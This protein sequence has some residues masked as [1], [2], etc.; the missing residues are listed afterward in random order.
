VELKCVGIWH[1]INQSRQ[2]YFCVTVTL[3][4]LA[5]GR[6]KSEYGKHKTLEQF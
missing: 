6:E 2:K 4:A 1:I 3:Y 5:G